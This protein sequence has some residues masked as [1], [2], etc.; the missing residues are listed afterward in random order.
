MYSGLLPIIGLA[1]LLFG[2]SPAFAQISLGT[3]QNFGHRAWNDI[4]PDMAVSAR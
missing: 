1:A 4:V 2:P 3:A